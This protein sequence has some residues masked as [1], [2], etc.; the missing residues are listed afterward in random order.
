MRHTTRG[1]I[2]SV[3]ER[4]FTK[5]VMDQLIR[6]FEWTL[7]RMYNQRHPGRISRYI[8]SLLKPVVLRCLPNDK[9]NL[10][11]FVPEWL[12]ALKHQPLHPLP[13]AKR[14]FLF[15][16]Y[17]IEFTLNLNLAVLLAW[18]GH[19]VTIGY[20]PKLQSPI[21]EPRRDHPSARPY[22][23]AALKD[24]VRLSAGRVRCVDMSEVPMTEAR[25]DE[26]FIAR[27]V[28]SDV[29]M[30]TRRELLDANDPEVGA[31]LAYYEGVARL[32]QRVAWSYLS[33]HARDFDLCL[34]PNGTTFEAAQFCHVAQLLG[35]LLNTFEKFSFRSVRM[36]N[37]GDH[38]MGFDDLD[39]YWG[40]RQAAGYETEPFYSR[41][42]ERAM[43]L[44]N[45]HR[46]GSTANWTM[47]LQTAP[48]LS[49]E[50]VQKALGIRGCVLVCTNVPFDAGYMELTTVFQSMR[51]WLIETVRFLLRQ[52][53][54]Q[55]VVRAHPAETL[56]WGS[57]ERTED[58]LQAA[59]LVSDRLVV[60]PGSAKVNTYDLVE[61]C[62]L[63]IV[64]SS[65]VGLEMAM[66]GKPA[67]VGSHVYYTR[68]GFT[69]DAKDRT[70]YFEQLGQL[71]CGGA[72]VALEREQ[73][74]QARLFYYILH[75]V[76]QWPYPYDKPSSVLKRPPAKLLLD[77]GM[78]EYI[79]T[80]DVLS[81]D[82]TEWQGYILQHLRAESDGVLGREAA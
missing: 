10:H 33:A 46:M 9:W 61:A 21:K 74:R 29:I 30:A 27:R 40:R 18:R 45:E 82:R 7:N 71:T 32:G 55:V 1:Y 65:T 68:R 31:N 4:V 67:L 60:F 51:S 63:G 43:Q 41:A 19:H 2:M 54:L 58:I 28:K 52:T 15:C 49:A 22:L 5:A 8:L 57:K 48:T 50:E 81:F 14:I 11:V 47:K 56:H 70:D 77:P 23:A 62:R 34:I 6:P 76:W 42:C 66:L 13:R 78:P 17:R 79:K 16:A 39:F 53:N 80:L 24:V 64:F 38:C 37:H 26:A 69:L 12:D 73:V 59:G 35:M 75:C 3:N 25:L 72:S 20:L 44:L 36:I